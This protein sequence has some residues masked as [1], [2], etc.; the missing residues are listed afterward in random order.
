MTHSLVIFLIFGPFVT[1]NVGPT[2][3]TFS[4]NVLSAELSLRSF[5]TADRPMT[6]RSVP[7]V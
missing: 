4:Q 2:R 7:P 5:G 1:I 3:Q 6:K